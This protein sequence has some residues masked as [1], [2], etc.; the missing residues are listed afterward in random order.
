MNF[1]P[2]LIAFAAVVSL[3]VS[4]MAGNSPVRLIVDENIAP[5][6]TFE[7][8]FDDAMVSPDKVGTTADQPPIVF[9]PAL[10]G[11]FVWLSQRSGSFKPGEPLSLATTYTV[12]LASGLKKADGRPLSA[13]L[14]ETIKTPSMSIK[15]WN[16]TNLFNLDDAPARPRLGVIFNA[17]VDASAI[18]KFI[19]FVNR[20]GGNVPAVLEP[21]NTTDRSRNNFPKWRSNDQSLLT[22]N[23]RFYAKGA[24]SSGDNSAAS[25]GDGANLIWVTPQQPLPAGEWTLV[26]KKGMPA[27]ENHLRLRDTAG[28]NVGTVRP[29]EVFKVEATNWVESGRRLQVTFSKPLATEASEG[30]AARWA[31]LEPAPPNLEI[32]GSG[33]EILCTGDFALATNYQLIVG[34]GLP[35]SD[36]FTLSK[37]YRSTARFTPVPPRLYLEGFATH[38]LSTGSRHFHLLAI[39][40]PKIHLTARVFTPEAA[41]G[42]LEAYRHYTDP[43]NDEA[44]PR[45]EDEP[46]EKLQL[47]HLPAATWQRD[48]DGTSQVDVK[49]D[50]P[51]DWNEILDGKKSGVV[52]LTA[53]E[54]NLPAGKKGRPGVQAIVQVTDLGAIWKTSADETFVHVFSLA[55]GQAVSD[56]KLQTLDEKGHL[57]AEAKADAHGIARLKTSDATRWL[58]LASG[59]DT[60]LVD[61]R[62]ESESFSLWQL[63][64]RDEAGSGANGRQALLFT[65]RPVY[66]PGE[67]VHLKGIVRDVRDGHAPVPSGDVATLRFLDPQGRRL[68][69]HVIHLSDVGSLDEDFKLP[70]SGLGFYHVELAM[71]GP[72]GVP[73]TVNTQDLEVQEYTP[74]AF[75]IIIPRPP[76]AV[77][78]TRID[79]P[80]AA[81]YY[82]GKTLSQAQ[83]T[84]TVDANDIGFSPAGFEAFD[85]CEAID[86]YQLNQKLGRSSSFSVQGKADLDFRG[87]AKVAAT[88]PINSKA[89][90]PRSA[91]L[92]C[93]ITDLDQQTVS[94]SS[95]FT[96]Q[97]S[98]F[99][100]GIRREH[101]VVREGEQ[102]P[103]DVVAVRTDGS[104]MPN[105]VDA[106]VRLT[107]IDWQTNNLESAG[108]G[109]EYRTQA[110]FEI[111]SEIEIKTR[112]MRGSQGKWA[113]AAEEKSASITVGKPGQYL[114][115]AM[116]KD[117]AG[118]PVLTATAFN[119]FGPGETVWNYRNPFQ[120]ELAADK[121][122]YLAGQTAR[123]LVKTPISGEALVTIERDKVLRS[124]ITH[125][126]GNAPTV[127]VP[128]RESDA[129]NVFVSVTML[130]GA[131]DSPKKYKAPEYRLGYCKLVV[132][133]PES[134]LT[135]YVKPDAPSYRPGDEVSVGAEVLD[136]NGHPVKN[137]EVTLFAVDEGVLSLMGYKTPDPFVFFN[138]ERGLSV[139][140]GLTLPTLLPEDP[141]QRSYG[142]KGYL[143]GGGGEGESAF[144]NNFATCAFWNASLRTGIDGRVAAKFTAPDALT[145]YRLMAIV[146]T[147]RD[148]FGSAESAFEVNK[149]LM[150]EP[151]LPRFANIGDRL[152]VRGVL[153][154]LTDIEGEVDVH[155]DF[156]RT[157]STPSESRHVSLPAHGS[158]AVDIP[159]AFVQPGKAVWK[160][161]AKFSGGGLAS[162]DAVQSTIN[163]GYPVPLKREMRLTELR[164]GQ[165]DLLAGMNPELLEG[166]GAIKVSLTNSRA[167]ELREPLDDL[168]HYPYGCVEQTT[169]TM[170]PWISIHDFKSVLPSLKRSDEE[171]AEVVR[172]GVDRLLSMQTS[173]GGLAYWPGGEE[174]M[175]WASAY[176]GLGMAMA[177][178]AGFQVPDEAFNRLCSYLSQQ[179]RGTG[180]DRNDLR[181]GNSS[182]CLALYALA[183]AGR[184]EPAYHELLFKRRNSLGAENRALLALAVAESHGSAAM[185]TELLKPR[186]EKQSPGDDLFWSRSRDAAVRLLAWCRLQPSS[187]EVE[188]LV[189]E[190]EGDRLAGHWATT[191]G[192][193]WSMLALGEYFRHVEKRDA[194]IHGTLAWNGRTEPI[195]VTPQ[196]PLNVEDFAFVKNAGAGKAMSLAN[197]DHKKIFAEVL[198]ESRPNTIAQPRQDQG[199]SIRRRYAKVDDDGTSHPLTDPRVGDRVLVTLDIIASKA[200]NYVAVNDPLPA[201]LEAINPVFK[202]Q[203]T[204]AGER[205]GEEWAGDHQELRDDCAVFFANHLEPG[206]YTIR[207]LARVRAAGTVTA[208]SAKVEEMYHPERFGLT[209]TLQVTSLPL[210]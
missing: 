69:D 32:K 186:L 110:R 141:E 174:P 61:F 14:R 91:H 81:Q 3:A 159:V 176:G 13:T 194:N 122:E 112:T 82:M 33:N 123:V 149:Q 56:A 184:A 138:G 197:P 36:P 129:P 130:R 29:F 118:H 44:H 114:L 23:E 165:A 50:I 16:A 128:L 142:N 133:R 157:V 51:L 166:T 143:V 28:I 107:R 78:E 62:R 206:D 126:Q 79:L 30:N 90:Q 37:E 202:S 147:T 48:V 203:E 8:R 190:L 27:S 192:D 125:L 85:F 41:I 93:E 104:P 42:A 115:E 145:R 63:G 108:G 134:K 177:R 109:S 119:V 171:I 175:F 121:V 60:H 83:M 76:T 163:V 167:I 146:H 173:S 102:L 188:K 179:L 17:N 187:P 136:F 116:S 87:S 74:N 6:S 100:L 127:E 144:R 180:D 49:R 12:T 153:H 156:D 162:Q 57:L 26:I 55:S 43:P 45:K 2:S 72:G 99:Y 209:E 182:R 201:V 195:S 117:D 86:D 101:G 103:I 97:S 5:A 53:E 47:D 207:Y 21:T 64:I 66:K 135:V 77:G 94:Q 98:D 38:Q 46:F 181:S 52:L 88:I 150:L 4:A 196:T 200:A 39:N 40:V 164:G 152:T 20:A 160:W 124:F 80:V 73:E 95:E 204:L 22:W 168:L 158:V 75:E 68:V 185:I 189:A 120:I 169:S 106:T 58:M 132:A 70:A 67:T 10:K 178:R 131:A 7:L 183:V 92:L 89:P 105:P 193:C 205:L 84:W 25:R 18:A 11:T 65:E 172:Q 154:N 137:A 170:L 111:L 139:T 151:A 15:G 1:R 59:S 140:T 9:H 54:P 113:L 71:A 191:Q 210:K 31:R 198:I 35:S 161:A 96:I 34:A 19:K 155:V 199:Y 208:P 24:D 148:Q